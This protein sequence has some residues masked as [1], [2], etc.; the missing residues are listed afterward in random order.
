[1]TL[2]GDPSVTPNEVLWLHDSL[3]T[4]YGIILDMRN[5]TAVAALALHQ[6]QLYTYNNRIYTLLFKEM[7]ADTML[8]DYCRTMQQSQTNKT[9]AVALLVLVFFAILTAYY[10]L[11]YRHRLS[12][13]FC[14]EHI[15]AMGDVLLS[16]MSGSDKLEHIETLASSRFPEQLQK[17]VS[18]IEQAL[19]QSLEQEQQQEND[20][21]LMGDLLQRSELEV[22]SL[23][24]SN[25]VLDNCLSAL[26]HETMYYPSRIR[27]LVETGEG[28]LLHEVVR[29]YRELYAI[30]SEQARRQT[31]H[32]K[33]HIV[34]LD[35][36]VLGDRILI[37]YLFEILRKQTGQRQLHT[38]FHSRDRLYIDVIVD[39]YPIR[40]TDAEAA[41][42]FDPAND[43]LPYL[44]CRQIVR[45]HGEAT[46][47]RL[48]GIWAENAGGKT[49]IRIILP[50]QLCR[51]SK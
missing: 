36:D 40:F 30:L 37:D 38:S 22:A 50:R 9:V 12:Y 43:H 10:L 5:E 39:L 17:V 13:R 51:T 45:E 1:M 14:V 48:C 27:Q 32:R 49:Q 4:N 42:L 6:W 34:P 3:K 44:L 18:Q 46:N 24:V 28:E 26:K 15:R 11:Y 19:R 23:H 20:L 25:A 29:Y 7:S 33:L 47:R 35:N 2:M 16:N 41:H 8:S 31:E 21:E